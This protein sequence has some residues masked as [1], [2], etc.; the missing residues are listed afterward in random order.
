MTVQCT[1]A[2][3]SP[4]SLS[5]KPL[6]LDIEATQKQT[7]L[8]RARSFIAKHGVLL[9]LYICWMF[10]SGGA[11]ETHGPALHTRGVSGLNTC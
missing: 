1:F 11:V 5:Q 8:F 10:F 4:V 3:A 2:S 6:N 9:V 7:Y